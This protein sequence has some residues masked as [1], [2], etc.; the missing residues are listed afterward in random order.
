MSETKTFDDTNSGVLF[1]NWKKAK[2]GDP[3]YT[4]KLNVMGV[5]YEVVGHAE[6]DDRILLA[7]PDGVSVGAMERTDKEGRHEKYPDWRGTM[8]FSDGKKIGVAAWKR[9]AKKSGNPFLSLKAEPVN[10]TDE[11]DGGAEVQQ[12]A[13]P[14]EGGMPF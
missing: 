3:D 9:I 13:T 1:G 4:G 5:D 12:D 7:I 8:D 2:D 10:Q 14:S 11:P 6:S